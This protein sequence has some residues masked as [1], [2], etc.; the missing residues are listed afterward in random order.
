MGDA[1]PEAGEQLR[2]A[3]RN[4]DRDL[5]GRAAT[6][7]VVGAVGNAMPWPLVTAAGAT[8]VLL[9]G[10]GHEPGD[11]AARHLDDDFP[12]EFR[13]VFEQALDGALED[14]ELLVVAR[15]EERL[16]Y[17]LKEL[18]R[19]GDGARVPPLHMYDLVLHS[20]DRF[21]AYNTH[22]QRLL[23]ARL[24][25]VLGSTIGQ[26]GLGAAVR[27]TNRSRQLQRELLAL[28][29]RGTVS[30]AEAFEIL[31]ARHFMDADGYAD[32]LAQHLEHA[33][34][35]HLDRG[36]GPRI[37]LAPYRSQVDAS[38][39]RL[40]EDAGATVVSEYD[41]AGAWGVTDDIDE[42]APPWDAV[43]E[44]TW[45]HLS[46]ESMEPAAHRERW[47]A[48]E[49]RGAHVD[50]VVFYVPPEDRAFGWTVPRL[51]AHAADGG[52]ETLRVDVSLRSEEGRAQAKQAVRGFV[53]A[54]PRRQEVG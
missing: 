45:R 20:S 28:R 6:G 4:G 44:D 47:F 54:L 36:G 29:R 1:P 51:V 30:G 34:A 27:A 46:S 16:Y 53:A 19:R 5:A 12:V 26:D 25:R 8:P 38:L 43:L 9:V 50:G 39:H 24:E 15:G 18:V 3:F 40:V 7:P 2:S 52:V 10:A 32:L 35:A 37:L 13:A 22:Q 42:A 41:W 17:F 31:G 14:L 49:V 23:T 48:D 21:R 11:L 33:S